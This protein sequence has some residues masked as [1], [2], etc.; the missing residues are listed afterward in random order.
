MTCSRCSGQGSFQRNETITVRIP[1]GVKDGGRVRVPRKGDDGT[2]GGPPGELFLEIEVEPHPVFRREGD[3]L[4]CTVP[5]TITEA[6]LGAKIEV[7]T[8]EGKSIL[9]IPPGTQS[10][11]K[12][13][14]Q[15]KAG[16]GWKEIIVGA[17][18]GYGLTQTFP[19]I[20]GQV[21]RLEIFES[22]D[23][24]AVAEWQLYRPE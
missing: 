11:Q 8:I 2:L 3:D 6:A 18:K 24:A 20:T 16:E 1:A 10:G 17:T 22:K 23:T 13:R 19:P 21:F 14:L 12:F 15:V 9:K 7:P 5:I 4:L